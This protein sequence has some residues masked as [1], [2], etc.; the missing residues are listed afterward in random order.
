MKRNN[1]Q[2][3]NQSVGMSYAQ[4]SLQFTFLLLPIA[5]V[6]GI[7]SPLQMEPMMKRTKWEGRKGNGLDEEMDSFLKLPYT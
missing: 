5:R 1:T 4:V 6:F 7:I 2:D 3:Y